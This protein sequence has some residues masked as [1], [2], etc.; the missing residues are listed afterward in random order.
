M[1][2][3]GIEEYILL[4]LKNNGWTEDRNFP[5]AERW[6]DII[7]QG[8]FQCFAYAKEILHSF[9]GLKIWEVSPQTGR[10]LLEKYNGDTSRVDKRYLRS[11]VTVNSLSEKKEFDRYK[12]ASFAFDALDAFLDREIVLDIKTAEKIIGAKLFPIGT[13][14]PD[15]AAYVAENKSIYILFDDSIYFAGK[16]IESYLNMMFIQRLKPTKIL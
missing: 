15:G 11:W 5:L 4:A 10:Y 9:G 16:C 13:V 14:E 8:G 12:G 1:T 3:S 6:I 2:I 7:E